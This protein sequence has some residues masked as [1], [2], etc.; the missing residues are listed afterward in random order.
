[1][2]FEKAKRRQTLKVILAES[3]MV[4][5]VV[6]LVA[7][8]VSIVSGYWINADFEVER[9]GLLQV[10]SVPTGAIITV[11]D[12]TW[13]QRTNTSKMV[14]STEHTVTVS[15]DGYDTWTKD[16]KVAE[17]LLYRLH[18]P[19]LFLK[20]RVKEVVWPTLNPTKTVV[21]PKH[22]VML[23]Y[24]A[25]GWS[26]INL[27]ADTPELKPLT[28]LEATNLMKDWENLV[29]ETEEYDENGN[30]LLKF[31]EDQYVVIIKQDLITVRRKDTNE[32]VMSEKL[33]FVPA[34][35]KIGHAGEFV[36]ISEGNNIATLVMETAKVVN[37]S[38]ESENFGWLDNDMIYVTG[39]DGALTVYDYDGLNRREIAAGVSSKWPVMITAD[40]WLYYFNENNALMREWLIPR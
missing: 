10:S 27:N 28:S 35:T 7:V 9:S 8:L 15:K 29:K 31:Y 12:S 18:Y 34:K 37:W 20:E 26:K 40:K 38:V 13:F 3:I 36:V 23:V 25:D 14:A 19:R 2:D 32:I 39:D 17:G 30:I 24:Q 1:M 22:D 21:S 5:S 4:M 33:P 16:I 6:A 11:D